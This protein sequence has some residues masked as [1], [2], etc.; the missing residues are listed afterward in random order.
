VLT[1]PF[2]LLLFSVLS[3]VSVW[4]YQ[5]RANHVI[6]FDRWF[7]PAVESQAIDRSFRIGQVN[8][9]FV[10]KMVCLATFEEKID[11]MIEA[12]RELT[13][14]SIGTGEQWIS[15]MSTDELSDLFA[16]SKASFSGKPA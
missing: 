12:K 7:N 8:N 6:L 3:F 15:K 9:V 14:L 16:L 13:Q 5:R 1:L 4:F 10:H 11:Q 2:D